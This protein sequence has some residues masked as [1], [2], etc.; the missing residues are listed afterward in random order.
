MTILRT[1][2]WIFGVLYASIPPYW[3]FVHPFAE[4]WRARGAKLKHVGP[5]WIVLWFVIAAATWPWRMV[6]LYTSWWACLPAAV[7]LAVAYSIYVAGTKDFTHDQLVG[8]SEIEPGKHEQ[9]LNTS[10]IRS[11]LR[12]PLYLGHLLHLV[13]WTIGSGL[14]VMYALVAFAVVTG[15]WMVRAEERELASRF[16]EPYREYQKRVPAIVP[17]LR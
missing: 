5:I 2:A 8:R 17:R 15:A 7:L 6:A 1:I 13:G 4:H 10:G 14:A 12:H 16:G 3:L 9:R 11:R